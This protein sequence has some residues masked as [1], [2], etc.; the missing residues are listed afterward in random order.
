MTATLHPFP[1]DPPVQA[2]HRLRRFSFQRTINREAQRTLVRLGLQL[3]ATLDGLI[4][5]DA[6]FDAATGEWVEHSVWRADR[7][8]DGPEILPDKA[9]ALMRPPSAADCVAIRT[10]GGEI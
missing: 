1:G 7:A 8:P 2:S 9:N 4:T 5:C 10:S 3:L 6:A